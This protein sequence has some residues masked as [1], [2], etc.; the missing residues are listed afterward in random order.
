MLLK[1]A[2]I[3]LKGSLKYVRK[4]IS[5]PV[6]WYYELPKPGDRKRWRQRGARDR[7]RVQRL[8]DHERRFVR[9][10]RTLARCQMEQSDCLL[11]HRCSTIFPGH[12]LRNFSRFIQD[13]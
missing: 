5:N 9:Y 3:V 13:D 7:M 10:L 2:E 11:F 4:V 8:R 1:F 6:D 12:F